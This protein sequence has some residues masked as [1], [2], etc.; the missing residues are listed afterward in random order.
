MAHFTNHT[1]PLIVFTLILFCISMYALNGVNDNT[2]TLTKRYYELQE[3]VM[4]TEIKADDT[5]TQQEAMIRDIYR[6]QYLDA[7]NIASEAGFD[8]TQL[9]NV[10]G[11]Q[12]ID[13]V[14]LGNTNGSEI[15]V[16]VQTKVI[17]TYSP[18]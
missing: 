13:T 7:I 15:E 9:I 18:L 2:D 8:H 12:V 1:P 16:N 11:Y 14:R 5:A 17:T 10:S 4:R 3:R 6:S